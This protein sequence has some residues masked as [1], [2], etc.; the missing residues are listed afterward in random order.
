L[1]SDA[2]SLYTALETTAAEEKQLLY[3]H[4]HDCMKHLWFCSILFD[5]WL[6]KHEFRQL[7]VLKETDLERIYT[8][9]FLA[10]QK[11]LASMSE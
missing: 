2:I 7:Q 11:L 5:G 6:V 8:P 4:A 3:G 1:D 9:F 10:V